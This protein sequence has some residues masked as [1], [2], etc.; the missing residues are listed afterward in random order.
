MAIQIVTAV[1]RFT[2]FGGAEQA[3]RCQQATTIFQDVWLLKQTREL[4]FLQFLLEAIYILLRV[5]SIFS[6]IMFFLEFLCV[7]IF[8]QGKY[9]FLVYFCIIELDL[10]CDSKLD[11]IEMKSWCNGDYEFRVL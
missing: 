7:I 2:W 4:T 10:Q 5:L 6:F 9:L 8:A 3:T 11:E 1:L